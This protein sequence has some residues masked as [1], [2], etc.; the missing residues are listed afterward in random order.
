[1]FS[2]GSVCSFSKPTPSNFGRPRTPTGRA[3][4]AGVPRAVLCPG[5]G[6][7][8]PHSRLPSLWALVPSSPSRTPSLRASSPSPHSPRRQR[9]QRGGSCPPRG[10][11]R[12]LQAHTGSP[13][14]SPSAPG[15]GCAEPG[16]RA[17]AGKAAAHTGSPWCRRRPLRAGGCGSRAGPGRA[18][19]GRAGLGLTQRPGP[20][21]VESRR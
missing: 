10:G 4:P 21:A 6:A 17:A 11:S 16:G 12:P 19:L 13:S 18:G 7:S 2:Q 1:M 14:P 20:A 5:T 15:G 3:G 8:R 9:R